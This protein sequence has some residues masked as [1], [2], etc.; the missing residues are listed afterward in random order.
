MANMYKKPA[1]RKVGSYFK[2]K[3]ES[4]NRQPTSKDTDP[5]L[6]KANTAGRRFKAK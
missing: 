4:S 1:G 6:G 2:G 5:P 3:V